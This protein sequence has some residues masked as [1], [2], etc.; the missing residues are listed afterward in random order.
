VRVRTAAQLRGQDVAALLV[1]EAA[2]VGP[3]AVGEADELLIQVLDDDG[4]VVAASPNA[5]GLAPVARLRSGGSQLVRPPPGGPV[6]DGR[7]LLAVATGADTPLGRQTVVVAR[8]TEDVTER[9]P[10]RSGGCWRSACRCCW[11][12]SG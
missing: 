2:P 5:G 1:S 12:W 6:E 8:S 11:W 9:R 3:L 10:R 4:R 7:E